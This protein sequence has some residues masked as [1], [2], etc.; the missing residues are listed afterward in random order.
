MVDGLKDTVDRQKRDLDCV[1]KQIV[2]KE[3]LCS[4]LRVS[5]LCSVVESHGLMLIQM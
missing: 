4:A 5:R 2:E 1:R 3:M